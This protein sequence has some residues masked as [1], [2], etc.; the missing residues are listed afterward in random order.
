MAA[1]PPPAAPTRAPATLFVRYEE[2]RRNRRTLAAVLLVTA[3]VVTGAGAAIAAAAPVK[4]VEIG[5]AV[6]TILG[7]G[8]GLWRAGVGAMLVA[9]VVLLTGVVV[10]RR[11][12][13]GRDILVMLVLLAVV[14]SVLGRAVGPD[15]FPL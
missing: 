13:L 3:A 7:W 10:R 12:A 14:G 4:D 6:V 5:G 15:W 2:G 8:E 1:D 11:W 9:C